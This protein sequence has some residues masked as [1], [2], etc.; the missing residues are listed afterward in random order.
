MTISFNIAIEGDLYFKPVCIGMRHNGVR[1]GYD[2][3]LARICTLTR[4]ATVTMPV[5][6]MFRNQARTETSSA[7]A[8]GS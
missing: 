5:S 2:S 1:A 8:A 6:I 3:P 7:Y 4:G